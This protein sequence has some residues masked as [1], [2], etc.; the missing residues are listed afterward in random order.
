MVSYRAAGNLKK[1]NVN[2]I[3]ASNKIT[4]ND[5][6]KTLCRKGEYVIFSF[7]EFGM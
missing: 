4:K 3:K 6:L 7:E 1:N 5:L 2:G